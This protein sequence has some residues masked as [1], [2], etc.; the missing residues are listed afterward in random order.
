MD[1]AGSVCIKHKTTLCIRTGSPFSDVRISLGSI[2]FSIHKWSVG[3]SVTQACEEVGISK[4]TMILIYKYLR[5]ICRRYFVANPVRLG[6]PGVTCQ[7]DESLF[8]YK[9]KYHRGRAPEEERWV[10]GIVDTRFRPALGYMESVEKRDAATLLPI[11]QRVCLPSTIIVSDGWA[12]YS[13]IHEQGYEHKVV[14]HSENFVDPVTGA[15]TQHIESY[16]AKSK[17]RL[18]AMKGVR[19]EHLDEYLE[20]M[21]WLERHKEDSFEIMLSHM[22][23]YSNE[24][25]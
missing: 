8:G 25:Q 12:A 14:N 5:D 18:K 24:F 15:H 1:F 13:R 3:A 7:V 4:P 22:R 9:P 21:M 2:L 19:R 11:I 10:F 16:W 20:E 23:S 17:Q 6:G